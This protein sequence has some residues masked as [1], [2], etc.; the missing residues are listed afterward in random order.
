LCLAH[1]IVGL[2]LSFLSFLFEAIFL[3]RREIKMFHMP[4][5][6]IAKA[7]MGAL[8]DTCTLFSMTI[9]SFNDSSGFIGLVSYI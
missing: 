2:T 6:T 4:V 7:C 3:G 9:A 8:C 5:S 1:G